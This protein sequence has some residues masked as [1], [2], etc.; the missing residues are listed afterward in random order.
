MEERNYRKDQAICQYMYLGD[1]LVRQQ[2][3][4]LKLLLDF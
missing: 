3:V 1:E 4:P 2:R